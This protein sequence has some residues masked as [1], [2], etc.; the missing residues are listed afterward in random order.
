MQLTSLVDPI[1]SFKPILIE[2]LNQSII[3][4]RLR[5]LAQS[6]PKNR[7]KYAHKPLLIIDRY[8]HVAIIFAT[9]IPPTIYF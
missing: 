2:K 1:W 8:I 7:L 9:L 3:L 6:L 4:V 5:Q